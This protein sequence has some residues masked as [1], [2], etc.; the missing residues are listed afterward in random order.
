MQQVSNSWGKACFPRLRVTVPD[1]N[2]AT[3]SVNLNY[4]NCYEIRTGLPG[5]LDPLLCGGLL[6]LSRSNFYPIRAGMLT[7]HQL[8]A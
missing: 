3:A 2:G 7:Q 5:G 1:S 6:L 8:R 4:D